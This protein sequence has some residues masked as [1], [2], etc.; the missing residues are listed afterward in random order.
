MLGAARD[1][2]RVHYAKTSV[3]PTRV[4][5]VLGLGWPFGGQHYTLVDVVALPGSKKARVYAVPRDDFN[6]TIRLDFEWQ[7]GQS[8]L[9]YLGPK[10]D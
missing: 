7:T 2:T 8:E 6:P 1:S 5:E 3:R 4:S 9:V 10:R